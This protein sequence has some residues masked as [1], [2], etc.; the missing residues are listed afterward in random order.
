M[1]KREFLAQVQAGGDLTSARE[2]ERWSKAV[3]AALID[4]APDS[5]TRRQ[6]IAQLPGFLKTPVRESAPRPLLMDHEASLQR[7]GAELG[8]HTAEAERVLACVW[9]VL[10]RA[11]SAGEIADF[12]ARVPQD[13]ASYLARVA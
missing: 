7:V 12:Q 3:L 9:T 10:R 6:F 4:L 8:A 1:N 11:I 5:E 2:A 13:V